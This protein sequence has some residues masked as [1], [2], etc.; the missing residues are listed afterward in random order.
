MICDFGFWMDFINWK[1]CRHFVESCF[2]F[3]QT[4]WF[5]IISIA[6]IVIDLARSIE[7]SIYESRTPLK[8]LFW[9]L[10]L[11]LFPGKETF[12]QSFFFWKLLLYYFVLSMSILSCD[13]KN[14]YQYLH[15]NIILWI[16]RTHWRNITY[17]TLCRM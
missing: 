16:S 9:K 14:W 13:Q 4:V 1:S 7:F 11:R 2:I 10:T 12:W 6:I 8:T 3:N 17:H 5:K 15:K